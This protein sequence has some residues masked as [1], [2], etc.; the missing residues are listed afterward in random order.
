MLVNVS[1]Y[2][3]RVDW[4][5]SYDSNLR[6]NILYGTILE[7]TFSYLTKTAAVNKA[8]E[9]AMIIGRELGKR[10]TFLTNPPRFEASLVNQ[11]SVFLPKVVA[12]ITSDDG[13]SEPECDQICDV[14]KEMVAEMIEEDKC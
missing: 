13:C 1:T 10:I 12:I 6:A 8:T 4:E 9:K 5:A 2:K 3:D 11:P 7:V 14:V